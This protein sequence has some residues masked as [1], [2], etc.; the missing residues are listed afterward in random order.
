MQPQPQLHPHV[1]PV[2]SY[3]GSSPVHTIPFLFS[4]PSVM[5]KPI[6][7]TLSLPNFTLIFLVWYLDPLAQPLIPQVV[8]T[9]VQPIAVESHP[10]T[11]PQKPT[12]TLAP[13]LP[14]PKRARGKNAKATTEPRQIPPYTVYEQQGHPTQNCPE[15]PIIRMHLD[16]MDTTENLLVV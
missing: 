14:H 10:P 3:L 2:G 8:L 1:Q 7:A 4:P 13:T 16:S 15:I 6:M 11:G 9:L 5:S 12:A